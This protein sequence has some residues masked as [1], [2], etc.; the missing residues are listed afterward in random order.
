MDSIMETG[1]LPLN[2]DDSAFFLSMVFAVLGGHIPLSAQ[3]LS[4]RAGAFGKPPQPPAP[5]FEASLFLPLNGGC[6]SRQLCIQ[7]C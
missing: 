4:E 5:P 2:G 7:A 3:D 6:R 1:I